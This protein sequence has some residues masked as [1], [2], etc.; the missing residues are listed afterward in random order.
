MKSVVYIYNV[1]TTN[2]K[3]GGEKMTFGAFVK[4]ARLRAGMTLRA[5]CR[6]MDVDPGN[7]SKIERGILPPPKSRRVLNA[8]A[9][10]LRL[11]EGSEERNALNDLAMISFIPADLTDDQTVVDKLPIFFR[12]LRGE[13]PALKE[14]EALIEKLKKA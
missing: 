7:W 14:L 9:D 13:K 4:E 2:N 6:S 11:E 12:T 1:V 10:V 8:I 5:F 3:C